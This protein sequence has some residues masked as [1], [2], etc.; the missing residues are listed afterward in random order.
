LLLALGVW[1]IVDGVRK[2]SLKPVNGGMILVILVIVAR[3]FDSDL[4]LMERGLAF[5][6]IGAGFFLTNL[7]LHR[8]WRAQ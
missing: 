4:G 3:F 7:L 5:V 1:F 6:V 8:K 2:S